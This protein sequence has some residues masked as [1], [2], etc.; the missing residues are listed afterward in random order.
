MCLSPLATRQVLEV[1]RDAGLFWSWIF[2]RTRGMIIKT[3]AWSKAVKG[4][5]LPMTTYWSALLCEHGCTLEWF[6]V[7]CI[8][9]V[10]VCCRLKLTQ[11]LSAGSNLLTFFRLIHNMKPQHTSLRLIF[12]E[13]RSSDKGLKHRGGTTFFF[14]CCE[15]A[16]HHQYALLWSR[17][18]LGLETHANKHSAIDLK[19]ISV[20]CWRCIKSSCEWKGKR[21]GKAFFKKLES[22]LR[23]S[24]LQPS[25]HLPTFEALEKQPTYLE[26]TEG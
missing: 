9:V 12:Y 14:C 2:S 17:G 13:D 21:R 5:L 4:S 8:L 19:R 10:G 22:R 18:C 26:Y 6:E 3:V 15:A 11:A 24:L 20:A 1:K 23:G 25:P 7:L 16:I